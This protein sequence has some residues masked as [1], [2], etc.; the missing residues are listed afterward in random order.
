[1][2]ACAGDRATFTH[3]TNQT[4]AQKTLAKTSALVELTCVPGEVPPAPPHTR[5]ASAILFRS[6]DTSRFLLQS[7]LFLLN[8]L[9]WHAGIVVRGRAL[10]WCGSAERKPLSTLLKMDVEGGEWEALEAM[11]DEDHDKVRCGVAVGAGVW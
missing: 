2:V 7:H 9:V 4:R 8:V 6:P 5:P 10:C 11:T 3:P 1:M